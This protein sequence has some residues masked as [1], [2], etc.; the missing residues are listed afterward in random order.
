[1]EEIPT[2]NVVKGLHRP[3]TWCVIMH[4]DHLARTVSVFCTIPL[5]P[6]PWPVRSLEPVSCSLV[7]APVMRRMPATLTNPL[8]RGPNLDRLAGEAGRCIRT[9]CSSSLEPC[10]LARAACKSPRGRIRHHGNSRGRDARGHAPR[11]LQ[12]QLWDSICCHGTGT[13]LAAHLPGR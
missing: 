12:R 13:G 6:A 8:S 5:R 7:C 3:A 4:A 1:M 2:S 10:L 9:S 11:G